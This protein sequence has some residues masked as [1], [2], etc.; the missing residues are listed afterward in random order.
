MRK[1]VSKKQST[2]YSSREGGPQRRETGSSKLTYRGNLGK[3]KGS[4][5]NEDLSHFLGKS[6]QRRENHS[7]GRLPNKL[8][9][10]ESLQRQQRV[11]E[12]QQTS[13]VQAKEM[14]FNLTVVGWN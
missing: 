9:D 13:I 3:S 12:T 2:V 8:A 10:Q 7:K 4:K 5:G 6:A 1:Y 14:F 11:V